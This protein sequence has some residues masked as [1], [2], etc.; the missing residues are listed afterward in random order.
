MIYLADVHNV[1]ADERL[2]WKTPYFMRYGRTPD[3]SKFLYFRF[4]QRVYYLRSE[5]KFPSTGERSGYWLG[6]SHHVGDDL[7]F[8]I[9]DAKT[10]KIVHRSVVRPATD[11]SK[12]NFQA[13][14]PDLD[15]DAPTLLDEDKFVDADDG[16]DDAAVVDDVVPNDAPAVSYTH[17]TLPTI[18]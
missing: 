12:P 8:K 10:C 14:F 11:A 17:L 16:G 3:I 7:T 1:V 13:E 9:M 6:V 5:E 4:W 2:K 15:D 18:A